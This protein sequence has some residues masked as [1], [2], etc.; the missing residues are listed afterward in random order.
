MYS[1]KFKWCNVRISYSTQLQIH[2]GLNVFFVLFFW[3]CI[4]EIRTDNPSQAVEV[5]NGTPRPIVPSQKAW[6]DIA[7]D[8]H[9]RIFTE[10]KNGS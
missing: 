4:W 10:I 5:L 6:L 2:E 3:K 1:Q 7:S 8:N 9:S